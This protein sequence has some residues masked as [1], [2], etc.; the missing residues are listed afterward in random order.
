TLEDLG[1]NDFEKFQWYLSQPVLKVFE[2]IHKGRLENSSRQVT[3][4]LMV[5]SYCKDKAV[6]ITLTILRKM[7]Q[8]ET[9]KKLEEAWRS[10]PDSDITDKL[11]PSEQATG[12][13]VPANHSVVVSPNI[14]K[15]CFYAPV[16][17]NVIL[18]I[19][20]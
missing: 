17:V 10:V 18:N 20:K 16:N 2:P 15:N 11:K 14:S 8:N 12:F 3:V 19:K 5:Q 1:T 9:A 6:T 4:D 7:N 13:H